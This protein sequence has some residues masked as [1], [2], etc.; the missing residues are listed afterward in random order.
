M[1]ARALHYRGAECHVD[2][3]VVRLEIACVEQQV[4]GIV[5][6]IDAVLDAQPTPRSARHVVAL[7]M[8]VAA[9]GAS[10]QRP[11]CAAYP[12]P[13]WPIR[14]AIGLIP[15][16]SRPAHA[17]S[18]ELF[19]IRIASYNVENLFARPKALNTNDWDEGKPILEAYEQ[20]NALMSEAHYTPLR[21]QTMIDL[22]V[23]LDVYFVNGAGAV[24]R[25]ETQEPR[26]A[27]LRKNRGAFDRQP[28]DPKQ[29][30]EIVADGREGWIGWVEL[31][32][33]AVDA[34]STRMTAR[35]IAE[36]NADILAVVE[37]EDRPSLVRFNRELLGQQYANAMLIDG[38]DE[39]GIDVGLMTRAGFELGAMRSNVNLTDSVGTVFSRDCPEYEVRT[40]GGASLHVLVNHFKSQS[41]GGGAKRARQAAATRRIA[42]G[43]VDQGRH[44]VVLGDLNEGPP[45]QG[46]PP[47][48]LAAL[49]DPAGPL[50]SCYEL[51]CFDPG[52]RPGTFDSCGLRNRLDYILVSKSLQAAV[53]GGGIFR[54]GLWGTRKTRPDDW[55]T[56]PQMLEGHHGASDHAAVFVD[57]NL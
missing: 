12:R 48:N 33:E 53:T 38:N 1:A 54:K 11:S 27:W 32:K 18:Q 44:V 15:E 51:P 25:R 22:L 4:E 41:G 24:R 34:V 17:P 5:S 35:V 13:A 6:A 7:P 2:E 43:L 14:A 37:A 16:A 9:S 46:A 47:A 56:Y 45:A 20:V 39:R 49:F 19:M 42:Q 55:P 26:W 23:A 40:P 57:L 52:P 8:R 3:A 30:V 28:E 29:S 31:Q 10:A 21:K 36:V 50:L